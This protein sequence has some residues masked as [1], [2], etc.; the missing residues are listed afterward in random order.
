MKVLLTGA[1]G[2]MGKEIGKGLVRAGHQVVVVSRN[3]E[4]AK[5]ACPFPCE[6]IE[7]DL[8]KEALASSLLLKIEAVIHL[9]GESV[10]GYRWNKDKKKRIYDSRVRGTQNLLESLKD[11]RIRVFISA[12]AIGIYGDRKDEILV[13]STGRGTGFLADVCQDWERPV[14]LAESKKMFPSCRYVIFRNG[15][16]LS[17]FDGAMKTILPLFR[18]GLGS[19]LGSGRQWM[20]WIHISDISNLYVQALS[21]SEFSG[22]YN[23][24]SPEPVANRIFAEKLAKSLKKR[25][26]LPAPE[27]IVKTVLGEM[28]QLVLF[29]QRIEPRRL[30]QTKFQ[31]QYDTL[32]KAQEQISSYFNQG[33]EVL[34][35]EQYLPYSKADVFSFFS[36]IK[37]LAQITP[38]PFR[39]HV[40]KMSSENL[41]LG[42]LI[43]YRL[44]IHGFPIKWQSEITDWQPPGKFSDVQNKGPCKKWSHTHEFYEMGPGTLMADIVRYQIPAGI[45]GRVVAGGMVAQ[46]LKMIFEYRKKTSGRLDFRP[47][48]NPSAILADKTIYESSS[49]T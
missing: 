38:P 31:F 29:S 45:F 37:N 3:A 8:G 35:M 5:S 43:D 12:S 36:E 22:I 20:S 19:V 42:S 23:A 33:D 14:L 16:V 6:V 17:P 47:A 27:P 9:A 32:D 1:T 13:E 21:D 18:R 30:A 25:L 11:S 28:S 39:F 26:F 2:F 4:K 49:R 24:V 40:L 34:Y 15:M 46:D 10:V 44:K 7:G 48:L 41:Q